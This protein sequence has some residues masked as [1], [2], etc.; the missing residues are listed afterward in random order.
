MGDWHDG[1]LTPRFQVAL[2]SHGAMGG[3]GAMELGA[4]PG[5]CREEQGH[6]IRAKTPD[7]APRGCMSAIALACRWARRPIHDQRGMVCGHGGRAKQKIGS[8]DC[9]RPG[10]L[11][12]EGG[13]LISW[14]RIADEKPGMLVRGFLAAL[15]CV[16]N[17]AATGP[18]SGSHPSPLGPGGTVPTPGPSLARR[19]RSTVG[20]Q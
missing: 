2:F 19:P 17:R 15:S 12:V 8:R 11:A 14:W 16:S 3:H 13:R 4:P 6:L 9:Q 1:L 18:S 10:V 20:R 7:R 5:P